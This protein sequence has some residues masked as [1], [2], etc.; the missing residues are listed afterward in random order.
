VL[1]DLCLNLCRAPLTTLASA[2][3]GRLELA[4][5]FAE[6]KKFWGPVARGGVEY[7]DDAPAIGAVTTV[8]RQNK[9]SIA[10]HEAGHAV[11]GRVLGLK[12]GGASIISDYE[13]H[14]AGRAY[15]Y[16]EA[17][18]AEWCESGRKLQLRDAACCYRA[19]VMTLMAGIEAENDCLGGN[20]GGDDWDRV[21]I[22]KARDE[23]NYPGDGDEAWFHYL[24]RLR[25]KTRGLVRRHRNK[26]E[27]VAIALQTRK[28]LT[29]EE[30]DRLLAS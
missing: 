15:T 23:I 12:C 17:T 27:R 20:C 14:S 24:D 5:K 10:I 11:I 29:A 28:T 25:A 3:Y 26:I 7:Q 19:M 21:E 9:Q 13:D 8:R 30:I 16:G 18:L 2:P 4:T 6:T 1:V 22:A